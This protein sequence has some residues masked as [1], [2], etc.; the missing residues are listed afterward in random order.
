M[1]TVLSWDVK[2]VRFGAISCGHGVL[3]EEDIEGYEDIPESWVRGGDHFLLRAKGDSMV[4][5]RIDD[6]DL[7]LIRK[8]ETFENGEIMAVLVD[9]D[10][11]LKRIYKTDGQIMLQSENTKYSPR[12]ITDQSEIRLI[13]KLK[14]NLI[15]Y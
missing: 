8:Q 15:S 6:G 1:T 3:A 13:G 7:L 9:G 12:F 4:N 14:M 2:L 10:A 5:A 11:V